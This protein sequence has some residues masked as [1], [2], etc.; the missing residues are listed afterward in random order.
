[1]SDFH[2]EKVSDSGQIK[3]IDKKG[4]NIF[5]QFFS[6]VENNLIVKSSF[7]PGMLTKNVQVAKSDCLGYVMEKLSLDLES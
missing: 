7:I 5:N 4:K 2:T 3:L 1:M 6:I